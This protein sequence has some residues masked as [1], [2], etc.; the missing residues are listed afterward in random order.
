[1][2]YI[3]NHHIGQRGPREIDHNNAHVIACIP[4]YNC[5]NYIRRAVESLLAQTYHNLT[6]VVVNDADQIT[7]PWPV[8]ADIKDPRLVRFDLTQNKGPYFATQ[9]VLTATSASY[10]LIQDSDDWSHPMRVAHLLSRLQKDKA[11]L[12]ISA[13]PQFYECADGSNR[14]VGVRWLKSGD[15]AANV[16]PAGDA[17]KFRIDT[18]LTSQYKYRSPHHGLFRVEALRNIGGYYG[19]FRF[20]Y[21]VL[22]TNLILMIGTITHVAEPLYHRLIRPTSLTQSTDTGIR[23]IQRRLIAAKTSELYK[24]SYKCYLD[25]LDAR[26]TGGEMT[27]MIKDTCRS[28]ITQDDWKTLFFESERLKQLF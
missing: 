23:S 12:A 10:L 6:V 20:N 24:I 13:Q 16:V 11:D 22:I 8:L 7:P 1:M 28:Y 25:F 3:K 5:I 4:Y 21:D 17:D 15:H 19:G 14:V 26:M 9:V 2:Q 27:S 18:K